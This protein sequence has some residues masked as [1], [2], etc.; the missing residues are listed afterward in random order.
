VYLPPP[1]EA[2]LLFAFDLAVTV[3][4][5]EQVLAKESG[6]QALLTAFRDGC[7]VP[8]RSCCPVAERIGLATQRT[9]LR[10]C[11]RV[12]RAWGA[13]DA[14]R[15]R[16]CRYKPEF[17]ATTALQLDGVVAPISLI[18]RTLHFVDVHERKKR[19]QTV[20]GLDESKHGLTP[21]EVRC[22]NEAR[23]LT[24][25]RLRRRLGAAGCRPHPKHSPRVWAT[26][27]AGRRA[28]QRPSRRAKHACCR[29]TASGLGLLPCVAVP[30]RR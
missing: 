3:A 22:R 6:L 25:A 20:T 16:R 21:V 19:A 23:Q 15:G 24:L 1:S 8:A 27:A 7:A 26:S 29:A 11:L 14:G 2:S 18:Y 4:H 10:A 9:V 17:T 12:H 28:A 5:Q 30:G 13:C